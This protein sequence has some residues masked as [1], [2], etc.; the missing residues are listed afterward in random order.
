MRYMQP[1]TRREEDWGRIHAMRVSVGCNVECC[2]EVY[3]WD[4]PYA[5][6]FQ[7]TTFW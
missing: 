7:T 5:L 4:S 6:G 3:V 2:V 1:G